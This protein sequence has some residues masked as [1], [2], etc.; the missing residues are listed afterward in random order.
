MKIERVSA[1]SLENEGGNPA[2]VVFSDEMLSDEKMLE[3]AKEV[4]YSETAFLTKE[5]ESYKIRY[6]SPET[7]IAFCGHA[8]IA[9]GRVLGE[10][11]GEGDYPLI[12]NDGNINLNIEEKNG[13]F[14]STFSSLN[15]FTKNI[16]FEVAKE[17]LDIFNL[18][19]AGLNPSFPIRVSNSGNNHP[20]VFLNDRDK[21]ASMEYDFDRAKAFMER[22]NFTTIS[23]LYKENDSLF[24]SRNAFAFGGVY[25]DPATGS[26]AVAL[27]EYLRDLKFKEEGTIEIL[28]GFDMKQPS[29][30][31]ATFSKEAKSPVKVSGKSR[32]IKL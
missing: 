12:L 17:L 5:G 2:G 29:R 32:I 13:E 22:E 4:N 10:K 20:I 27:A 31:F 15:T 19:V 1:F 14:I 30:L 6:F 11:F 21:L 7:E 8:T 28:Q 24:H 18:E 23:L 26:A 3:I 16:D 25:E 9:S